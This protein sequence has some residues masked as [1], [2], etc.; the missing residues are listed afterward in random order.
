MESVATKILKAKNIPFRLIRLSNK[1]I[2]SDDV[3][4]NAVDDLNPSEICKTI[5]TKDESGNFYAIILPGTNKIDFSKAQN[6]IGQKISIV[7]FDDIEKIT[8]QEPGAITPITLNMPIFV[9]QKV[10]QMEKI[11]F[12]SGDNL[13]GLEVSTADLEKIF[14][15][16]KVDISQ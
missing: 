8:G 15:F 14:V 5:I 3:I 13:F 9:D 1:S 16:Q 7:E 4:K 6:I 2:S 11:N 12:G 10:F